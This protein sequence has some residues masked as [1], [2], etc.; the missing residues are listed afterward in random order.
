MEITS[1]M[2]DMGYSGGRGLMKTVI[3]Y[4]FAGLWG[5]VFFAAIGWMGWLAIVF[6]SSLSTGRSGGLPGAQVEMSA[7]GGFELVFYLPTVGGA[8]GIGALAG[9]LIGLGIGIRASKER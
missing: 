8:I 6:F 3:K 2:N 5:G 7:D 9:V 4:G 1:N